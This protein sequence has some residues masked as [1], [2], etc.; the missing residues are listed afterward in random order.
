VLTSLVVPHAAF[1]KTTDLEVSGWIP[2]W[3]DTQGIKDAKKHLSALDAV[4]PFVFTVTSTGNLKDQSGLDKSAWKSF[5]K[6]AQK[7]NVDIIPTI[8]WSDTT[9]ME[10]VLNNPT[11]RTQHIKAIADMVKDGKYDGIDIDYEGKNSATK[12]G[13]SAFLKE[14]KAA[15]GKKTLVC[16]I[17][18]RTPPDSLYTEIPATINYVNDYAVI[19]TYCDQITVMAYDQQRAD[20]KLNA[21]RK[22]APY[23]PVA[24][25]D[26]VEKVLKLT[27]QSLPKEKVV[28]GIPTYGHHYAVTVAPDWYR[29]YWKVGALNVPDILDL[30]KEQKVK[31]SRNSAGEMGFSYIPKSSVLASYSKTLSIPKKTPT[32]EVAAAKA[33]AYANKTGKEATFNVVSYSDAGAMKD[34]IDL[35]K[36][37]G[38]RGVAL[39]KIDGEEDQ[40]VWTYLQ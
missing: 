19:G 4:Y 39:F 38:L 18:P 14:L 11:L 25:V 36:D 15:L 34:K 20:I 23:V 5:I 3:R 17:E 7:K 6:T 29:D 31:P 2:Y 35:A 26:W 37:L 10:T 16:T 8:M 30:A 40:K 28:L 21:A 1:A 33:L 9:A 13:F 22:G 24:D 32:G 27:L 12:D